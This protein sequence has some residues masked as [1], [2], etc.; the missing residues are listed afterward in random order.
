MIDLQCP[1]KPKSWGADKGLIYYTQ[2]F[3]EN[4]LDYSLLGLK[5]HNGIDYRTTHFDKGEAPVM[6]AH[7]GEVISDPDIQSDT[8]GRFVK[9]LS[10]E[11]MIGS[12]KCKIM[13]LYFHLSKCKRQLGE[14][15]KKGMLIG[16]AGNTG[17]FTSG[18]H[19]HFGMYPLL[20]QPDGSYKKDDTNGYDGAIDPMPYFN[21][22]QVMVQG[23]GWF[24]KYYVNRKS[25]PRE[26]AYKFIKNV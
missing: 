25:L 11:T 24:K 2:L 10:D 6:A 13:T 4:D 5:G 21:D 19:L 23:W 16:I 17:G 26:E 12:H 15:V 20:K 18:P 8:A 9:I 14:K 7:D 3:G 1:I 22:N